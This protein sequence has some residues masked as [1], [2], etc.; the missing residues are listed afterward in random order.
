MKGGKSEVEYGA[1]DGSGCRTIVKNHSNSAKKEL[2]V[3]YAVLAD[4]L[5]RL[6]A[7]PT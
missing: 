3:P 1:L 4:T 7:I 2:P 6:M 5:P